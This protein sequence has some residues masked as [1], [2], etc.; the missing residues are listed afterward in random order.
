MAQGLL[1][2]LNEQAP[3]RMKEVAM[4]LNNTLDNINALPVLD[5]PQKLGKNRHRQVNFDGRHYP[6]LKD[7]CRDQGLEEKDY[8]MI[9]RR[10]H[11]GGDAVSLIKAYKAKRNEYVKASL[12]PH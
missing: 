4:S 1:E 2:D 10:V 6:N 8:N 7:A 3:E 9:S 12:I 11:D 5:K